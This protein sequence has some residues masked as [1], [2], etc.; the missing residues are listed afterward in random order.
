MLG[1]VTNPRPPVK[2]LRATGKWKLASLARGTPA[3]T[4]NAMCSGCGSARPA[5]GSD[6]AGR[7]LPGSRDRVDSELEV[8]QHCQASETGET[9]STTAP[10]RM[11]LGVQLHLLARLLA[12][13]QQ[14]ATPHR[15]A[16]AVDPTTSPVPEDVDIFIHCTGSYCPA[17]RGCNEEC[18]LKSAVGGTRSDARGA[19]RCQ[20]PHAGSVR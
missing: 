3:S 9:A 16:A 15:P 13:P 8:R 5:D 19:N 10:P 20:L 2:Q 6:R 7:P 4:A 12:L 11:S 14:I 17:A 1:T 18:G